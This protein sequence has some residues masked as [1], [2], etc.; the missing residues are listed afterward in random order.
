MAKGR[1]MGDRRSPLRA[2][3]FRY[4]KKFYRR[5]GRAAFCERGSLNR[6]AAKTF[7]VRIKSAQCPA[8]SEVS[9]RSIR[10][11]RAPINQAG[12]IGFR[13]Y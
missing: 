3:L 10:L 2:Y 9:P 11:R 5:P 12:R 4:L 8:R 7:C 6:D 13:G 1:L